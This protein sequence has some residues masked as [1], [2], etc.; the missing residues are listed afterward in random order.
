MQKKKKKEKKKEEKRSIVFLVLHWPFFLVL[1]RICLDKV[2]ILF[3]SLFKSFAL[4][5]FHFFF[6]LIYFI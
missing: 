3:I 4:R 5:H 2:G 6:P 1:R